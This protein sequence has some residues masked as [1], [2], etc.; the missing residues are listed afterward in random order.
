MKRAELSGAIKPSQ[1]VA[2]FMTAMEI[3][4]IFV[5]EVVRTLLG[6]ILMGCAQDETRSRK[7][8]CPGRFLAVSAL[9]LIVPVDSFGGAAGPKAINTVAAT[10]DYMEPP[11]DPPRANLAA[12]DHPREDAR[13]AEW[14]VPTVTGLLPCPRSLPCLVSPA[15]SYKRGVPEDEKQWSSHAPTAGILPCPKSVPCIAGIGS[16]R[17]LHLYNTMKRGPAGTTLKGALAAPRPRALPSENRAAA[18][19]RKSIKSPGTE[20]TKADLHDLTL[21]LPKDSATGGLANTGA[22]PSGDKSDAEQLL[23]DTSRGLSRIN[24]ATLGHE[25]FLIYHGAGDLVIE[26]RKALSA[27]DNI[28]AVALAEKAKDLAAQVD[29]ANVEPLFSRL[30]KSFATRR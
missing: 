21:R 30:C 26:S 10:S 13:S 4:G 22:T 19:K 9:L 27:R 3:A 18:R 24:P 11:P 28:R 5:P 17:N 23:A 25:N 15:G 1:R 8:I 29:S 7:M 2:L 20:A 6:A 16:A 12:S 14:T